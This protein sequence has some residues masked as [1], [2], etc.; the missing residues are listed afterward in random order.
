[1]PPT[2]PEI[3]HSDMDVELI[4]FNT[5]I[6]YNDSTILIIQ[7]GMIIVHVG[8]NGVVFIFVIVGLFIV[9]VNARV[10]VRI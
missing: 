6:V 10:H 8:V 3:S 9:C 1:M 2:H 5:A 4:I 7:S